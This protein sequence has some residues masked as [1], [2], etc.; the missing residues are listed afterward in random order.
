MLA[1]KNLALKCSHMNPNANGWVK[2][3]R[4][5]GNGYSM[6][7]ANLKRGKKNVGLSNHIVS[8]IK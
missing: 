6:K 7:N 8:H 3:K 4:Q 2:K 5:R 1:N